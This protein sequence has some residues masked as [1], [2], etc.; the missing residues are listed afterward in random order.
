[1]SL[2]VL[3]TNHEGKQKEVITEKRSINIL[4]L[5]QNNFIGLFYFYFVFS[6]RLWHLAKLLHKRFTV[7]INFLLTVWKYT[8]LY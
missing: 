3:L 4:L 5:R 7:T 6:I 2:Y 8:T 1:M